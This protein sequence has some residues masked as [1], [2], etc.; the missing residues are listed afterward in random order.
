MPCAG[1]TAKHLVCGETESR[2]MVNE[3][4]EEEQGESDSI[5]SSLAT[6]AVTVTTTPSSAEVS[7]DTSTA[8]GLEYSFSQFVRDTNAN[9]EC[10]SPSD[11]I[12]D[13][14]RSRYE[15]E[16]S[17]TPPH[18]PYDNRSECSNESGH[19]KLLV[20]IPVMQDE[21]A[22]ADVEHIDKMAAEIDRILNLLTPQAAAERHRLSD[23][24]EEKSI[25]LSPVDRYATPKHCDSSLKTVDDLLFNEER[26]EKAATITTTPK[27]APLTPVSSSTKLPK[28]VHDAVYKIVAA[29]GPILLSKICADFIDFFD[30]DLIQ[31]SKELGFETFRELVL[32]VDGVIVFKAGG[33]MP[34]ATLT[35]DAG[36]LIPALD[37]WVHKAF[38]IFQL[39]NVDNP[40]DPVPFEHFE[41]QIEN[42]AIAFCPQQGAQRYGNNNHGTAHGRCSC[43]IEVRLR[44]IITNRLTNARAF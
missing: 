36:W 11:T 6:T 2:A 24:G 8:F 9:E 3:D 30:G 12:N 26:K 15:T 40:S 39:I 44:P 4:E 25:G 10:Q 31:S 22:D 43:L 1:T 37:Y 7:I 28:S 38:Q 23:S 21:E 41:Q 29:K 19:T 5:T 27:K 17:H 18:L 20:E 13:T 14:D 33:L 32:D 16:T 35:E 34:I 42:E